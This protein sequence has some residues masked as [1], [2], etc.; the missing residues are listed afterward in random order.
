MNWRYDVEEIVNTYGKKQIPVAIEE[1]AELTQALT[2][3]M[4]I[5]NCGQTVRKS[6]D[7]VLV[8]IKEEMAD[9]LLM[10]IQLQLLFNISDKQLS[11]IICEKIKR[12][13]EM[14]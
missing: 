10:I 6:I 8:D 3:Y 1:M 5:M 14:M 11:E 4:R 9:V 7:E 13:M 2:K 12:T